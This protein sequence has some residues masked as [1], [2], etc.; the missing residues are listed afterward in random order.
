M[1]NMRSLPDTMARSN[2]AASRDDAMGHM[3]L[4]VGTVLLTIILAVQIVGTATLG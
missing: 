2:G 1:A 4:L 3:R